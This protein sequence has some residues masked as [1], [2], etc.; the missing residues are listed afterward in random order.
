MITL[1]DVSVGCLFFIRGRDAT[2]FE[3][4]ISVDSRIFNAFDSEFLP[5]L[6]LR[7]R[8]AEY[9]AAATCIFGTCAERQR[10]RVPN[11]SSAER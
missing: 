7:G 5:F 4:L 2:L 9:I 6:E 3:Y 8:K 1:C 11:D 10:Q